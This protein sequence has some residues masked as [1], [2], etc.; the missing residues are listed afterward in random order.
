MNPEIKKR[1]EIRDSNIPEAGKGLFT[2][3]DFKKG[4][5]L[6]HYTGK[7]LNKQEFEALPNTDYTWEINR[8]LFVDAKNATTNFLRYVNGSKTKKQRKSINCVAEIFND[9]MW[10]II[11][12]DVPANS[13]IIISYGDIYF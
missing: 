6:G 8:N 1:L 10:Y 12:K 9:K 2:L 4:T 13:E 7:L 11:D 5:V 3:T